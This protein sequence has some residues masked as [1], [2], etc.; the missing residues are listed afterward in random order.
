MV[1]QC[2]ENGIEISKDVRLYPSRN[3]V[4]ESLPYARNFF[5]ECHIFQD[6][7]QFS[8]TTDSHNGWTDGSSVAKVPGLKQPLKDLDN[9][10]GSRPP[11]LLSDCQKL[12]GILTLASRQ[13]R[14]PRARV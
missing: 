8:F 1:L 12:A 11:P 3:Q 5:P 14:L 13:K 10:H 2:G 4:A 6:L 7:R 9:R